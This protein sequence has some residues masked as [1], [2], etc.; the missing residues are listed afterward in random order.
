MKR[1]T[2]PESPKLA[3]A[4]ACL[5]FYLYIFCAAD[6]KP[7]EAFRLKLIDSLYRQRYQSLRQSAPELPVVVAA[8]DDESL[9]VLGERW[10]WRRRL[11]AEFL[12]RT[13]RRVDFSAGAR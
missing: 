3:V 12:D 4:A 10:P 5:L 1:F 11:L 6:F 9:H 8:I 13:G 7:V 2:T